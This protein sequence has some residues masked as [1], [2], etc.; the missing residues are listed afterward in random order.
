MIDANARRFALLLTAM[1][2]LLPAG[3]LAQE[4][5]D[6]AKVTVAEQSSR[7]PFR[8]EEWRYK[9]SLLPRDTYALCGSFST[10]VDFDAMICDLASADVVLIGEQHD[11][12]SGHLIELDI[13]Q[14]LHDARDGCMAL[15]LEMFERDTQTALDDYLAGRSSE[16]QFLEAA[17]PWN[18]YIMGYRPLIEFSRLSGI[19]VG[20]GNAPTPL[21]RRVARGGW[22]AVVPALTRSERSQLARE[23]QFGRDRYWDNF[24][25]AMG[26]MEGAHGTGMDEAT[27]GRF[28]EA[29]VVKDETMAQTVDMLRRTVPAALVVNISGAF[30]SDF[31]LG[32]TA[33]VLRRRPDDRVAT[34]SLRSVHPGESFDVDQEPDVAD[35]VIVVSDMATPPSEE[36]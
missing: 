8:L 2:V 26:G 6:A 16:H 29:Q 20:A 15:S 19:A 18:N 34:V 11:S 12:I 4:S 33:R 1:L 35:Y 30:H 27:M 32:T 25:A 36:E 22:D 31:R 24:V 13:L 14:A 7:M 9:A 17:R 21:S 23:V 10:L 3:A 28:Y 5:G